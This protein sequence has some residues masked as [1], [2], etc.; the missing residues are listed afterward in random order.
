MVHSNDM[1]RFSKQKGREK[2]MQTQNE[3][4]MLG[5]SANLILGFD[6]AWQPGETGNNGLFPGTDQ[7]LEKVQIDVPAVGKTDYKWSYPKITVHDNAESLLQEIFPYRISTPSDG[8]EMPKVNMGTL[9]IGDQDRETA[10][11]K[12]TET[13]GVDLSKPYG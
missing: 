6:A 12:L 5:T 9:L 3:K 11:K 8:T 7:P 2:A 10:I 13:L 4:V 1:E